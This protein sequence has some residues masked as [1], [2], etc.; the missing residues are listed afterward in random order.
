MQDI[1]EP[2]IHKAAVIE[3]EISFKDTG[4]SIGDAAELH[5]NEEGRIAVYAVVSRRNF[6]IRRRRLTRIGYLGPQ[7]LPL[8]LPTLR[9][10]DYLRVRVVGLTPEHLAPDGR[11][12]MSISGWGNISHLLNK[13][14]KPQPPQTLP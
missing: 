12:E 11:A 5:L 7:A 1:I 10:G 14:T 8:L 3:L 6:L 9:K 13:T 4:L 2:I